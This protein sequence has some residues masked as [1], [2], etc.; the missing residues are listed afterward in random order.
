MKKY[1]DSIPGWFTEEDNIVA[2]KLAQAV[3]ENGIIVEIGSFVGK[4]AWH[5]ANSAHPSVK[6]YCIDK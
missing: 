6:I 4:S 1:N 5:W 2:L 3:P